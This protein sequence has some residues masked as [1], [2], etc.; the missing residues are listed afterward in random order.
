LRQI[1]EAND[2]LVKMIGDVVEAARPL[3]GSEEALKLFQEA[4][5][6]ESLAEQEL[7]ACANTISD[8]ARIIEEA[9]RRQI[10]MRKN[11]DSPLPDEEITEAILDAC[12]AI[13]NATGVLVAA[14]SV[15]QKELT[16]KGK[17]VKTQNLY[18]RDPAWAKGLISAA[19]AVAGSVKTLVGAAN[20][21]AQGK[22]EEEMLISSAK[23]VAAS[24]ARLVFASRT[25]ADPLSQTQQKL[26]AAA[27]SVA[28]ATKQLV[29]A[30]KSAAEVQ[31]EQEEKPNFEDIGENEKKKLQLE[32]QAKILKLQKELESAQTTLGKMRKEEY[33]DAG[34]AKPAPASGGQTQGAPAQQ[35]PKPVAPRVVQKK[36]GVARVLPGE[37]FYT[38][39]QL[40]QRPPECDPT[41]LEKYLNDEDFQ[42]HFHIDKAN[43]AKAPVWKQTQAKKALG[44]H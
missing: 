32:Q 14:S 44:I 41:Q 2:N 5:E 43:F 26:T 4:D 29:D 21:T 20:N 35:P 33:A 40:Q 8:A 25:K 3:P 16:A 34:G 17:A 11:K 30:A 13:A 37:K 42:T 7:M 10:E 31:K 38:L 23:S 27:K 18:K 1:S 39:E 22:M 36:A 12:K 28:T 6:L 19:Q 9:K 15:A 24:T